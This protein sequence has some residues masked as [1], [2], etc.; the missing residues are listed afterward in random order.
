MY[1]NQS[2]FC[3]Y[4]FSISVFAKSSD[5]FVIMFSLESARSR[6]RAIHF[7]NVSWGEL[8]RHKSL[9]SYSS[10]LVHSISIYVILFVFYLYYCLMIRP[11]PLSVAIG[12]TLLNGNPWTPCSAFV[13][14]YFPFR[15]EC[16][17]KPC[18]PGLLY[19]VWCNYS[20]NSILNLVM[21]CTLEL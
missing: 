20:V 6:L 7:A 1:M 9:L 21:N 4:L 2:V 8:I 5:W 13:L 14:V 19:V 15:S 10:T 12:K 16:A 11:V 18:E 3:I 17:G